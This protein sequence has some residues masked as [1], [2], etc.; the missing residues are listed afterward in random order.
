M[1]NKGISG[2][3]ALIL[4][5]ALMLVAAVIGMT[6]VNT[7]STLM[8]QDKDAA[9]LKEK[10]LQRPLIVEQIRLVDLDQDR[11]LDELVATIRIRNG[12]DPIR[13]NDTVV[14][15]GSDAISCPAL[16]YGVGEP[17]ACAYEIRYLKRGKYFSQDRL[18]VGDLAEISYS[19]P[20][21]VPGVRDMSTKLIFVPSHG[22]SNHLKIGIPE[23]IQPSHMMVYPLTDATT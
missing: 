18:A 3:G 13:F 6:L 21:I 2:I 20:N 9:K 23:R 17:V 10:S 7:T 15:V 22:M 1:R 11:G 4:V 19:G 14:M 12:D 16:T 8:N 5:V